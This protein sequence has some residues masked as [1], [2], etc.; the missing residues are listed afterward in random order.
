VVEVER[1]VVEVERKVVEVEVERKVVE[2]E[3]ERKRK[4]RCSRKEQEKVLLLLQN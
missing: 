2:V 4:R 1:K 3:V